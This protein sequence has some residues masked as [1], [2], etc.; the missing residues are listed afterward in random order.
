MSDQ[1]DPNVERLQAVDRAVLTP[2]VQKAIDDNH[3]TVT[4][5]TYEPVSGGF[6]GGMGGTFIYRFTGEALIA[7]ASHPWSII[8][9]VVRSRP[10]EDPGSTH[11]WKRE[12]EIYR[13]GWLEDLPGRFFAVRFFG[14]V[15]YPDEACWIWMEDLKEDLGQPWPLE[16]YGPVA[17]HLGQFNGAYQTGRPIPA[18]P[19]LGTGWLRKIA[20]TTEPRVPQIQEM[21][22][23]PIL[24]DDLPVDAE[25]QF[26]RLWDERER[27]L[28]V[29][30]RLPQ[31]FCHQDPVARNLFAVRG[32]D[33]E[34]NTVAI[35]WAYV[36][37]ASV[38][39]DIAVLLSIGLGFLEI[40]IEAASEVEASMYKHYLDG[41]RDSGWAGDARQVRLGFVTA[42][43][44]KYIEILMLSSGFLTDPRQISVI[45]QLW[46]RPYR[47]V[48]RTFTEIFRFIFGLTDEA[49]QLM[50]ELGM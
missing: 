32:A 6:G 5:W 36:G 26:K 20:Q 16:H 1:S 3:A 23:D 27:F 45:E 48:T 17:R 11:Y 2:L 15:E 29:L 21:L 25:A 13:S 37:P 12:F 34:Y 40:A 7:G 41:L 38:G 47:E 14:V 39:M 50:D 46:G 24:R 49:R 28:S 30:D 19:W 10:G 4:N 22:K 31:T 42:T 9:K 35:D 18:A 43:T 44:C 8:L 33:G